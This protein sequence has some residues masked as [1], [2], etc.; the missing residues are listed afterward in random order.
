[1]LLSIPRLS[2]SAT[3][4]DEEACLGCHKYGGLE[5]EDVD[6]ARRDFHVDG[7]TFNESVHGAF[8][9]RACH[10]GILKIPHE[11]RE[12]AVSCGISCH[13]FTEGNTPSHV[14]LY[15]RFL[16]T[17]HGKS[18]ERGPD[19]LYC[20]ERNERP[21]YA[22]GLRAEMQATCDDCH[23][24][25]SSTAESEAGAVG[26]DVYHR[27]SIVR[28]FGDA[29]ACL[30]CHPAHD[31]YPNADTE[32]SVHAAN[33]QATCGGTESPAKRCHASAS[34]RLIGGGIHDKA[35]AAGV[36]RRGKSNTLWIIV[37][38]LTAPLALHMVLDSLRAPRNIPPATDIDEGIR[39]DGA[40]SVFIRMTLHQRA[41]HII[42]AL[43]F[44]V[45]S[46]SGLALILG[47]A[48]AIAGLI[49]AVGGFEATARLHLGA[50]LAI[51]LLIAY[52]ISSLVYLS[53]KRDWT[54]EDLTLIPNRNDVR[55]LAQNAKF[56]LF[57]GADRPRFGKY[58]F[59][60]KFDYLAA[61]FGL[62][63]MLASGLATGFPDQSVAVI[64]PPR[65][66]DLR[67]LHGALGYILL[68]VFLAWHVYHNLLAP[69]KFFANWSWIVGTM[70]ESMV[71]R[72]H[73]GHYEQYA[74]RAREERSEKEKAAEERSIHKVI[75]RQSRRLEEYLEEGNRFARD[76]EYDEAIEQ[77]N[78]ALELL[79]NFPQARYNLAAVY[80][81]SGDLERAAAEY[82]TFIEM[83][84]FNAMT[85]KVRAL[86]REVEKAIEKKAQDKSGEGAGDEG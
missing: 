20:H 31:I 81:K 64:P 86:L 18:H 33:I 38:L 4:A 79:P 37:M 14:A 65:L 59:V 41:L 23:T 16:E 57:P 10:I 36:A 69:G 35:V 71:A 55:H 1:M 9:C 45:A 19:C 13:I 39:G 63:L 17:S 54:L 24:S 7:E 84:P 29:P 2:G 74:R 78:K 66:G 32:S 73:A 15:N 30:D 82:G 67:A 49:A 68:F 70:P 43:A 77:Y 11:T 52:H 28:N 22:E 72:D 61:L 80:Q 62:G 26:A 75:S 21:D 34:E 56:M 50:G 3:A 27:L 76:E 5:A 47:D 12:R 46:A 51:A 42:L 40:S 8:Q 25:D 58:T 83:D 6:G 48:P 44:I 60:Q 53:V 85:E